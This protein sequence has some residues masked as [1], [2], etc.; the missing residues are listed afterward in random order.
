MKNEAAAQNETPCTDISYDKCY[1][2]AQLTICELS[3]WELSAT[4]SQVPLAD[5]EAQ[6][7]PKLER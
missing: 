6:A 2:G 7:S 4:S 1:H 5:L 3:C